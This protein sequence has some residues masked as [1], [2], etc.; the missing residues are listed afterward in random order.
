MA[1]SIKSLSALT[2]ATGVASSDLM[3]LAQGQGDKSMS[4]SLLLRA[5]IDRIYP[6]GVVESFSGSQNPNSLYPGQTWRRLSEGA[7]RTIRIAN[8]TASDIMQTGGADKIQL[9]SNNLPP[10]NHYVNQYSGLHG[11]DYVITTSN[12]YHA[13]G[14]GCSPNG[15]HQ[16]QDGFLAP[17]A[18]WGTGYKGKNNSGTYALNWTS[19]NGNHSHNIGIYAAGQHQHVFTP[20][21]HSHLIQ[22]NTGNVGASWEI[23]V[24]NN[25]VNL[26]FWIR[27]K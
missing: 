10:H 1:I 21:S 23:V 9:S 7:D 12:G 25:Y 20:G 3:H 17:G 24:R 2:P 18:Q 5:I 27:E 4:Y 11:Q 19:I 22:G 14:A 15:D 6:V 13:H 16:H 8:E 26:A